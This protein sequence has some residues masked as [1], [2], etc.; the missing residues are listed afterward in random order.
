L[1]ILDW[2]SRRGAWLIEDD[3]DSEYRYV[4][5]PLGALQGMATHE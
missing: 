2:A 1:E 4:S 3:Y 5:R